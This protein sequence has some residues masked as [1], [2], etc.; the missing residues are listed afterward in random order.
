M[1]PQIAS[2][3]LVLL[4]PLLGAAQDPSIVELKNEPHHHLVLQNN[5]VNV[6]SVQV[7]PHD[8]VRLHK[9]EVNAIGIT[10][11]DAVITV[12][13]P[14]KPDS[15]QTVAGGQMRLQ[16]AGYIHSTA[17]EDDTPFRNVTV[18]LLL[19]QQNLH[20]VCATVISGKPLNCPDRSSAPSAAIPS[21]EIAFASDATKIS[22][23]RLAPGRSATFG[24][25]ASPGLFVALDDGSATK[26]TTG[27]DRQLPK[28]ATVW[29]DAGTAPQTFLNP[30]AK[31]VR[32]VIFTF[33]PE[34]AK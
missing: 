21:E 10:I 33:K 23:I 14:G 6:Y 20:N 29:R 24:D 27:E 30:G 28:G 9:H 31:E 17:V 19:P 32:L 7:P 8:L 4:G 22:T 15:R 34:A 3:V 5:Y 18:E 25:T 2:G 13:S 12:A 11:N 1:K 16:P 26:L